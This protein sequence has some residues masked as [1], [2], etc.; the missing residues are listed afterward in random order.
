[1]VPVGGKGKCW[2]CTLHARQPAMAASTGRVVIAPS[3]A[4]RGLWLLHGIAAFISPR[5]PWG[6]FPVF[7]G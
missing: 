1:M 4:P 3:L 5:F 7:L 2:I 6:M